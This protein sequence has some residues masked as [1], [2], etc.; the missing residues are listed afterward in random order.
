MLKG[1]TMPNEVRVALAPLFDILT[2]QEAAAWWG[3]DAKGV[4]MRL[5]SLEKS[6]NTILLRKSGR[7]W[8][9]DVQTM[10]QVFGS[11]KNDRPSYE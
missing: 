7:V 6:N 1:D 3:R 8:L 4:L 5:L 11:P 9:V 10:R 2:L